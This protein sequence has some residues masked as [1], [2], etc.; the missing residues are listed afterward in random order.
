[1]RVPAYISSRFSSRFSSRSLAVAAA[2]A[3]GLAA[4]ALA[5]WSATGSGTATATLDNPLELTLGP[6]VSSDPIAPGDAAGVAV[7]AVNPNPYTARL[8]S[9]SLDTGRGTG[10]FAADASHSGCGLGALSFATQTNG[11][12]GWAVPP[13]VGSTNGTL[14]IELPDALAMSSTA[15]N[16]CQGT[17]FTVYLTGVG[18]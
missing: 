4:G 18:S 9:L 11:G 2:L 8:Q 6:G 13:K 12:A 5:F 17:S 10:G 7:V 3:V 1:M 16:A 14:L 15:A